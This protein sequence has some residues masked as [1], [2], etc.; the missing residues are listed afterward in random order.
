MNAFQLTFQPFPNPDGPLFVAETTWDSAHF[1][2]P[3]HEVRWGKATAT[4]LAE[5]L[6]EVLARIDRAGER[7]LT[8]ARV[9]QH[10]IAYIIALARNGFYPVETLLESYLSLSHFKPFQVSPPEDFQLR[11]VT[12]SDI[13]KLIDIA[14]EAFHT[15]RFH[16]DPNIPSDLATAR[17]E[18]WI[19]R[20]CRTPGDFVWV[21]ENTA[22]NDIAGFCHFR[23]IGSGTVDLNL[24]AVRHRYRGT[25][26][27]TLMDN[28]S[29][30]E[31]KKLG[32]R[33]VIGRK[34]INNPDVIVTPRRGP[35][36]RYR[37][38]R[39]TFH[40]FHPA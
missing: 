33:T 1:G 9:A 12:P 6:P 14:R 5:H 26:L 3:F 11:E 29:F 10:E 24:I 34:S 17:Y 22:E 15:D 13:P 18:K 7:N 25:G 2:F 32:F 28:L 30:L 20:G 23:D 31:C 40:R 37:N 21:Y 4:E 39:M 36:F 38:P 27:G 8:V 19:E 35:S 16:L